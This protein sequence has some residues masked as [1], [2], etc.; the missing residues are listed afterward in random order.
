MPRRSLQNDP[1]TIF[2][3]KFD[4]RW[5][6][7]LLLIETLR[8]N[9]DSIPKVLKV[10]RQRQLHSNSFGFT[11]PASNLRLVTLVSYITRQSFETFFCYHQNTPIRQLITDKKQTIMNF[12]Y[13]EAK[14]RGVD[15]VDQMTRKYTT[16]ICTN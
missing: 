15:S 1:T 4:R 12:S 14:G 2:S 10:Y 8:R 7:R 13:K 11:N 5:I 16:K 3:T 6:L 9:R